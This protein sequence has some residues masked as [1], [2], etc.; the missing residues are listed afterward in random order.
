[1]P[2]AK[3]KVTKKKVAKKKP[4]A[5]KKV[6]KKK[7]ASKKKK[8][9]KKKPAAKKKVAKKKPAAKKKVT[10]KKPVSEPKSEVTST[11]RSSL[12]EDHEVLFDVS[13]LPS[14][15]VDKQ[16]AIEAI[17]AAFQAEKEN[18]IRGKEHFTPRSRQELPVEGDID[19]A[20]AQEAQ[21]A[22]QE[23]IAADTAAR[24]RD[25]DTE[26]RIAAALKEEQSTD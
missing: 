9:A 1:K 5:K 4:A 19:Y 2:A 22:A 25:A 16:V 6:T 12:P 21:R 23:V 7:P 10:K 13:S 11:P 20:Y 15:K 3:K 14:K 8:V 26:Q 18:P 17:R 24:A